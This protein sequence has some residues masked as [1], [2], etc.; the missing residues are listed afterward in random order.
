MSAL[1]N[2]VYDLTHCYEVNFN[3][4]YR[5]N[6]TERELYKEPKMSFEQA[7]NTF[8]KMY[9]YYRIQEQVFIN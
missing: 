9:G 8:Q 6:T 2:F 4:W 3:R 7:S 1:E 5:A